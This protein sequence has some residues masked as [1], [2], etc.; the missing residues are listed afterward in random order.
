VLYLLPKE[1]LTL[2]I[3]GINSM[4]LISLKSMSM[5]KTFFNTQ[6]QGNVNSLGFICELYRPTDI[7]PYMHV[8]A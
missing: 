3:C 1:L 6:S 4:K 7:T 5:V 2:E 8:F